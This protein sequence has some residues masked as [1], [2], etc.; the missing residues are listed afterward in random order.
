MAFGREMGGGQ[1]MEA[2]SI[3]TSPLKMCPNMTIYLL[4]RGRGREKM[5]TV[6]EISM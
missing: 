4:T 1:E 5:E 6:S 3:F 2:A